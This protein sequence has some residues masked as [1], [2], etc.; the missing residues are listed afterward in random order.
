MEVRK[1]V[2]EVYKEGFVG[3]SGVRVLRGIFA[4]QAQHPLCR[5]LPLMADLQ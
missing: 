1:S 5:R 3:G 4:K 2:P